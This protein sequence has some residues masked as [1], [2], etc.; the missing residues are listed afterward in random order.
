MLLHRRR[1]EGGPHSTVCR[2]PEN[3][4]WSA[5]ILR[6]CKALNKAV[7]ARRPADL[8]RYRELLPFAASRTSQLGEVVTPLVR[9][10]LARKL[11]GGEIIVKDEGRLP[12]GSFKARGLVIAVSMAQASASS[13]WRCRPMAMPGAALAAYASRA[14]HQDD[15]FCPEDTPEV[16]VSEIELQVRQPF[17]AST[18]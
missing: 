14:R 5:T 13:T 12:N 18:V 1:F 2:R 9:C 17:T 16:N 8:W 11:G 7:L 4:C 6:R 3:R 10:H 15:C